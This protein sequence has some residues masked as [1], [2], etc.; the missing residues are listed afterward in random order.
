MNDSRFVRGRKGIG[1]LQIKSWAEYGMQPDAVHTHL[2]ELE[3]I[4]NA[5][6]ESRVRSAAVPA[7]FIYALF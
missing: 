4:G 6:G 3:A 2:S 7:S 1:D 5:G